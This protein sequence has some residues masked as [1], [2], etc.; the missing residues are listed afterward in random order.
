MVDQ[1]LEQQPTIYATLLSPQ[2]RKCR[3][4]IC[5]LNEVDITNVEELAMALKPI[6]GATNIKSENSTPTLFVIAPLLYTYICMYVCT[7][8]IP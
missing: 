7:C 8:N 1:L 3:D 5:T 4:D 2:M 6:K